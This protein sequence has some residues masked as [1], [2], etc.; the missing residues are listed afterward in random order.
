[1]TT[2]TAYDDREA[3]SVEQCA[4]ATGVSRA[5]IYIH[6]GS[7]KLPSIKL[8]RRRL[9]LLQSLREWLAMLEQ[10]TATNDDVHHRD[11]ARAAK[12]RGQRGQGR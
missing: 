7:G 8:G 3:L 1:M 6:I 5:E 11:R 4:K 2:A 12:A 9:V 10:Q